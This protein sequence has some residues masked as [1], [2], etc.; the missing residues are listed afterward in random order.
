[1]PYVDCARH[2]LG[3]GVDGALLASVRSRI[4]QVAGELGKPSE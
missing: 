2:C 1:M 3:I 4:G